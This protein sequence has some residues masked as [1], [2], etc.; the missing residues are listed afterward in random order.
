MNGGKLI[1]H[2]DNTY[3]HKI[4]TTK[5]GEFMVNSTHHQAQYPFKGLYCWDYK[6]IGHSHRVSKF[7]YDGNNEDVYLYDRKECEI[8]WYR[9]TNSLGI[10]YHPEMADFQR[11]YP[12]SI[13]ITQR[14]LLD[15]LEGTITNSN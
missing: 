12:E 11:D 7:H 2:Q 5:Y 15:F 9:S 10:Q 3:Y 8:V 1:Q 6:I 4:N 14:I 13:K